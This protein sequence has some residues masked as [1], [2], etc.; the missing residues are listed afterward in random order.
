M[1][2]TV[3][4]VALLLQ[5]FSV[6]CVKT[7]YASHDG[8]VKKRR[9]ATTAINI[10][11]AIVTITHYVIV[12]VR[13]AVLLQTEMIKIHIARTSIKRTNKMI[14]FLQNHRFVECVCVVSNT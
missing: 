14:V 8:I 11:T 5:I 3:E 6:Y 10:I 9:L 7:L 2:Q 4:V 13:S 1:R 12:T